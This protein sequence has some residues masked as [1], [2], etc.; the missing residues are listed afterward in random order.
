MTANL[1]VP[2]LGRDLQIAIEDA[3]RHG[4]LRA[5]TFLRRDVMTLIHRLH[6]RHPADCGTCEYHPQD[7]AIEPPTSPHRHHG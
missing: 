3:E 2:P 5:A 6:L 1:P 4:A 7:V